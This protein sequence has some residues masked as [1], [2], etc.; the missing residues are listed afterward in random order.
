MANAHPAI[1]LLQGIV[2]GDGGSEREEALISSEWVIWGLH[3]AK[4]TYGLSFGEFVRCQDW[5]QPG[6]VR[7]R[8]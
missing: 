6:C 1:Y 3:V 5:Y 7:C 8:L 2:R 4:F